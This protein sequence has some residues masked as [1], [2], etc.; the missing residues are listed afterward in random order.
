MGLLFWSKRNIYKSSLLSNM[1]II[2]GNNPWFAIKPDL[3]KKQK[4]PNL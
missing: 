2:V 1:V 4:A 3:Q